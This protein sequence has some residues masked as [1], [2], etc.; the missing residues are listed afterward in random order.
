M[1][2]PPR[3]RKTTRKGRGGAAAPPSP[4]ELAIRYLGSRRRFEREVRAH[5]KKKGVASS[6]VEEAVVRLRELNLVGDEETARAWIRDRLN[7]APRGRRRM[8]MELLAKG[9]DASVVDD[10]LDELVEEENEAD[11]ALDCLRRGAGKWAALPEGVA[12]R[13][14]WASLARRGFPPPA[15]REAMIR[16]AEETGRDAGEDF[17]E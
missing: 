14:M 12:R 13:R 6:E 10:A 8:R 11:A 1:P 2:L 9:V 17:P 7:F 3:S 4:V 5:L 16:F 15:C